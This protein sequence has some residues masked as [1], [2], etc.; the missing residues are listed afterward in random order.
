M[1]AVISL[2]VTTRKQII[3]WF[4]IL[5]LFSLEV[6]AVVFGKIPF[7]VF[8]LCQLL[9][10]SLDSKISHPLQSTAK[11]SSLAYVILGTRNLHLLM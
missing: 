1:N 11:S 9:L 10:L 2:K 6:D 8:L 3:Q 4:L 7:Y 5:S